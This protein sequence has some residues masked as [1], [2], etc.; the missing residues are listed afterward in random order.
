MIELFSPLG[1]LKRKKNPS[2]RRGDWLPIRSDLEE[3][4]W[5]RSWCNQSHLWTHRSFSFPFLFRKRVWWRAVESK[6]ERSGKTLDDETTP[7]GKWMMSLLFSNSARRIR[8]KQTSGALE[9]E[10]TRHP[11]AQSSVLNLGSESQAERQM[12]RAHGQRLD[13]IHLISP[14]SFFKRKRKKTLGEIEIESV[15]RWLV[16]QKET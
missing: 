12:M 7:K 15:N 1:F 14:F 10:E 6:G 11:W 8:K 13:G 2:E 5:S 9:R 3:E 16:L 4:N